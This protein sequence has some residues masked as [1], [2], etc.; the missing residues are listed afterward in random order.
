MN[1]SLSSSRRFAVAAVAVAVALFSVIISLRPSRTAVVPENN[2]PP[3]T[4]SAATAASTAPPAQGSPSAGFQLR[5]FTV[6]LARSGFEWT[7]EDARDTNAIRRLA[8][9]DGEYKRMVAENPRIKRRQ[10]VYRAE[11]TAARIERNKLTGESIREMTLPGLD[12][13]AINV[14]IT[15]ADLSPSG[16]QGTFIGRV[17]GRG[18]SMVTLAFKGGREAFTILSPVDNLYLL[19]EPREPGELIVKSIDPDLY[20]SGY[21]GNP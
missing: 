9:N 8:H 2:T 12:G 17:A 1:L 20:A 14:E 3:Q 11:T 16:Q 15:R 5:P 21:C 19:A 6:A 7:G 10:L 18:D 13:Q 4:D